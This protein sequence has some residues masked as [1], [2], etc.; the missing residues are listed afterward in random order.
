MSEEKTVFE[1]DEPANEHGSN[2]PKFIVVGV[3]AA[4]VLAAGVIWIAGPGI[5]RNAGSEKSADVE[6]NETG[7]VKFLMEQQWLIRMKLAKAEEQTVSRQVRATGRVVPAPNSQASVSTPV[8]GILSDKQLP[9]VGQYVSGGQQIA[10]I[11]QTATASEEAQTRAA[12]MQIEAQNAQLQIENARLESDKRTAAG[13]VATARVRL[14]AA[15]READ[16]MQRLF[17]GNA[18]SQRQLQAAQSDRE[19]A[20]AGYDAAVRRLEALNNIRPAKLPVGSADRWL[21]ANQYSVSAPFGGYVTRVNKSIGEQV[22]PG[23]AIIEI[24]N[25]DIVYVEAPIFERDLNLLGSS[26]KAT[27]WTSAHEQEF[28]GIVLDIGSTIDEQTR[29]ANVIFEVQNAG[30]ALRLGMQADVRLDAEQSVSVVMIPKES[31]IESEGKKYVY[32]L[33]SGEEFQR[34]EVNVLDEYGEN[35]G[36][37]SGI[38]KGERVVTQGAYQMRLQELRPADAGVHSHET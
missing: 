19:S 21:G 38:E 7:T 25:L 10:V 15:Q 9:R 8:A 16:R 22:S 36:I 35:V 11:R 1:P 13:D 29:A 27:F 37:V 20:Q 14:D 33:L 23:D 28:S 2:R 26:R 31:I 4:V 5:W 12:A 34:R 30:R 6:K 24:S 18:A 32:V 3:L 17:D